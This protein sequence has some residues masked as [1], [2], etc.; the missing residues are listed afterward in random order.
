[1]NGSEQR[2][3]PNFNEDRSPIKAFS[4]TVVQR[5]VD[6][7][8]G[9]GTILT[10]AWRSV[11]QPVRR[12]I[13]R[14]WATR[15]A[16]ETLSPFIDEIL[17]CD[18]E[19]QRLKEALLG[20]TKGNATCLA[21]LEKQCDVAIEQNARHFGSG[22]AGRNFLIGG[23]GV[24]ISCLALF[25]T[26]TLSQLNGLKESMREVTSLNILNDLGT[27]CIVVLVAISLLFFCGLISQITSQIIGGILN[28]LKL[29]I[30]EIEYDCA[31]GSS[32]VDQTYEK[33]HMQ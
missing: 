21:L 4:K 25:I 22:L 15:N 30:L 20:K 2:D 29:A 6:L 18:Y 32:S 26:M 31:C 9:I 28:P 10:S 7:I 23:L 5:F 27:L 1:M 13:V 8:H 3:L 16:C 11:A 12:W 24:S 14:R 33:S 17:A 19:K